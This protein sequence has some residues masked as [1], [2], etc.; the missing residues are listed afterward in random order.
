M[1]VAK[2]IDYQFNSDFLKKA[3]KKA[4]Y[5]QQTFADKIGISKPALKNYL[6]KDNPRYPT[7][8]IYAKMCKVLDIRPDEG[9]SA[10]DQIFFKAHKYRD[11]YSMLK[12]LGY[13]VSTNPDDEDQIC[14]RTLD[15]EAFTSIQDLTERVNQFIQFEVYRLAHQKE[16]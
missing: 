7:L 8:D 12:S 4:G 3:I 1:I 15:L 5:T 16:E 9:L 13:D 10:Q 14:I 11:L 2:E 6:K